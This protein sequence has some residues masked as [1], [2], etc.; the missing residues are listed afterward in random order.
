MI[1]AV[2]ATDMQRHFDKLSILKQKLLSEDLDPA[3]EEH[4]TLICE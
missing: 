3:K 2:L 4:K 1:G